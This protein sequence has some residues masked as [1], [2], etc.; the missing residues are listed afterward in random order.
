[1]HENIDTLNSLARNEGDYYYYMPRNTLS[2]CC[3]CYVYFAFNANT[4]KVEMRCS[5]TKCTRI[6]M[7][8]RDI[9]K[10]VS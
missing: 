9:D 1:M 4:N 3:K 7:E 5:S 8:E 10:D 6:I 2:N